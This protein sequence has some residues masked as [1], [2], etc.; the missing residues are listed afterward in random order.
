MLEILESQKDFLDSHKIPLSQVFDASGMR[1]KDYQ[2]Y[3]KEYD[4]GYAVG[5]TAC[6]KMGHTLRDGHGHCV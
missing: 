5:V 3:M 2:E 1:T 6:Q 4:Y